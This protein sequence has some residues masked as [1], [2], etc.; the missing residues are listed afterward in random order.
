M[1][2]I[3]KP[4]ILEDEI[5]KLAEIA[6]EV[7]HEFFVCILSKEQ[8]DYM[9]EKFQSVAAITDQIQNQG[10][11]YFI[12]EAEGE[13]IG[14]TGIKKEDNKLFLSKLYLRKDFRGKGFAR[15]AF[16]FLQRTSV[17]MGMEAI[18]LTVNKYNEHTIS[19]YQKLGFEIIR[20]QVAD[21]GSGFVMDD[22]VMEVVL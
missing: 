19:V 4:V 5:N 12:F 7:W 9:V 6:N 16:S 11:Q 10:Y 22:Y 15:K 21:I 13:Q 20:Q 3:F 8:I 2:I 17:E 1:D 18:W 14:Y